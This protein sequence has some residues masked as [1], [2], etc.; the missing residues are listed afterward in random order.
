MRAIEITAFG[1]PEVL[2]PRELPEPSP[3]PGELLIDVEHIEVLFLD[4]QMRSGWAQSHFPLRPP[5]VPGTGV[6]GRVAATGEGSEAS[7]GDLVV[8]QTGDSGAYAER[9]VVPSTQVWSV[10]DGVDPALALAALHDGPLAL[11]RLDAL[12]DLTGRRV[13]ITAAAGSL[14]H[15]FVPLVRRAGGDVVATAG[16][17][18][19]V[20]AVR[21][22]GVADVRDH[23]HEGWDDGLAPVDVV[24]DNSGGDTGRRAAAL[25]RSGGF[26]LNHGAAAGTFSEP[27]AD[28]AT[29][30]GIEPLDDRMDALVRRALEAI[31]DETVRPVIGSHLPLA[32]AAAAHRAIE[33][34]GVVGKSVLRV[35]A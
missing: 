16:G 18:A 24:V 3:A 11:A 12:G 4:T 6:A 30:I 31:R 29:V 35:R 22:L 33:A 27:T 9:V 14:G 8:A 34:R 19:K 15:W 20:E 10:P 32:E 7:I 23:R 13:L 25:L 28:D 2:Q 26:L 17:P 5:F 1:G 21:R